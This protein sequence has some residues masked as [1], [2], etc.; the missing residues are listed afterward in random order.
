MKF[1]HL[2]AGG[3][4]LIALFVVPPVLAQDAWVINEGTND[5]VT[6]AT[7]EEYWTDERMRSALPYPMHSPEGPA[8]DITPSGTVPNRADGE[9]GLSPGGLPGMEGSL[10]TNDS[11]SS[12]LVPLD[13][14]VDDTLSLA[15]PAGYTMPFPFTMYE[16]HKRNIRKYPYRTIGR[17]FF[18][19]ASGFNSSCSGSSIGGRA[20]LTAGHCVSDGAGNW[21][22]NW[23]FRPAYRDDGTTI[24]SIAKW[25]SDVAWTY[26]V[27]HTQS[28]FCRDVGF[29]ITKDHKR[30]GKLSEKV[31]WLGHAWNW[32]AEHQ[33]WSQFGYPA[34]RTRTTPEFLFD[35]TKMYENQASFAEWTA[36][37]WD[38]QCTPEP[39]CFG[40]YMTG[41]CSGGPEIFRLDPT[42]GIYPGGGNYANGVS[43]TY[44]LSGRVAGGICSP[45]FDTSVHDFI[46]DMQ[47]E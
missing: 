8:F 5:D 27:W 6:A 10:S 31:G 26:T 4:L 24:K 14:G 36:A 40:S 9:P 46:V 19:T 12:E 20:V 18:T 34:E 3:L 17:L 13:G 22:S 30:F 35:G 29:L 32:D 45:Y 47:D 23:L 33:H 38:Q 39:Y 7:I 44:Y 43:S 41:G 11:G 37:W 28:N 21:H 2:L 15:E 1:R 25:P 16:V 42:G